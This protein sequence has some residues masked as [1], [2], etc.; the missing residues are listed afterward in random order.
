MY[1]AFKYSLLLHEGGI[2][3]ISSICVSMSEML[4][5]HVA[6]SS[7]VADY[8]HHEGPTIAWQLDW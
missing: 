2:K 7:F 4:F 3:G 6:R 5:V 8:A 1:N